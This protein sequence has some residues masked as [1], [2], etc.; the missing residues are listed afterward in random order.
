MD[1][2]QYSLTQYY[3]GICYVQ[4]I[5][6]NS[7]VLILCACLLVL[8]SM[9]LKTCKTLS[10]PIHLIK[11][12]HLGVNNTT[13]KLFPHCVQNPAGCSASAGGVADT[14]STPLDA[15]ARQLAGQSVSDLSDTAR[16]TSSSCKMGH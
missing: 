2:T 5:N 10:R 14:M 4:T 16:N 11:R 8:S 12:S 7:P 6:K 9:A 1:L 13:E 15:Q 3:E